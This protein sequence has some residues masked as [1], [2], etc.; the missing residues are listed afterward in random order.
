MGWPLSA[1]AIVRHH[2][3]E[4]YQVHEQRTIG[5]PLRSKRLLR[6]QLD[7]REEIDEIDKKHI[8]LSSE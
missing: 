1:R 7:I 5:G 4:G 2:T 6:T 8:N 3:S